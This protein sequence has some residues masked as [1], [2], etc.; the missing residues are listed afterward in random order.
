MSPLEN[1]VKIGTDSISAVN[2]LPA[3]LLQNLDTLSS[4]NTSLAAQQNIPSQLP[5]DW[6]TLDRLLHPPEPVELAEIPS[7]ASPT[8]NLSAAVDI[9]ALI[10]KNLDSQTAQ[11]KSHTAELEKIA[12]AAEER[13]VQSQNEAQT[14]KQLAEA[15]QKSAEAAQQ[16]AEASKERARLAQ[17]R[18]EAAA[19]ESA[20]AEYTAK[21]ARKSSKISNIIAALAVVV[22]LLSWLFP[23]S[24][25]PGPVGNF[26]PIRHLVYCPVE[27]ENC[28]ALQNVNQ[29]LHIS[30]SSLL[31]S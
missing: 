23:S 26:F 27:I 5:F 18:A 17:E 30:T 15:S 1:I 21:Q 20:A 2:S 31:L 11:L 4:L 28:D 7:P 29:N 10:A 14:S 6:D 25:I 9:L 22:A 24:P 3:G 13:A 16:I 12:K 19:Q 8:S